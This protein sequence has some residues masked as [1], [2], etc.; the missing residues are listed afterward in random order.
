MSVTQRP[1]R[2]KTCRFSSWPCCGIWLEC[3]SSRISPLTSITG[4]CEEALGEWRWRRP[5]IGRFIR[6]GVGG[7]RWTFEPARIQLV[8]DLLSCIWRW[9]WVGGGGLDIGMK[10]SMNSINSRKKKAGKVESKSWE[11]KKNWK[12][13]AL[14]FDRPILHWY[15][16][17]ILLLVKNSKLSFSILRPSPSPSPAEPGQV[18]IYFLSILSL[19]EYILNHASEEERHKR[20]KD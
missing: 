15:W 13:N 11:S 4:N 5:V 6:G 7:R 18:Q 2:C 3:A 16:S 14:R 17:D 8:S 1:F 10:N 12:I 19:I 9:S 20:W